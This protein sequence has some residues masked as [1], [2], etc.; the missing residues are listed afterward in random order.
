[1]GNVRAES[2]TTIE[3]DLGE[4]DPFRI[5]SPTCISFSGGRTSAYMLW[6]VLQSNGGLPDEAIV[7]FAN[8]GKEEEATLR[9]VRDCSVN[10]NVPIT[11]VEYRTEAP[12]YA[13]VD[14]ETASRNGAPFEAMIDKKNYL[15]NAVE[16]FC[17]HELKNKPITK[18]SGLHEDET[19]IGVRVD[20]SMR[21][22]KMR[23][24]GFMLPLVTGKITKRDV[25]AFWQENS[26]DL[27]LESHGS[28]T[29]LGN[30]DLCFMKG[31]N[32]IRSLVADKPSRAI[33]WAKQEAKMGAVFRSDRASYQAMIENAA[34]QTDAF[35]YE[36]EGMACF[37][38]D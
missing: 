11:W 22:P 4:R 1:M 29:P 28:V 34:N 21:I 19:M 2:M 6:R 38:G 8:T 31:A 32:Q 25:K 3:I 10:W 36:E 12:G 14:F 24:R 23:K 16:R 37:C 30:C 35:G 5:D 18:F 7:C 15:P 26:F 13:V 20:E 27:G 33:W 17:T 9:F